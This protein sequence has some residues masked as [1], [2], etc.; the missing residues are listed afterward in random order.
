MVSAYVLVSAEPGKNR[1]VAS[2]LRSV[3][4]VKQVHVCWGQ[5]D[6]FVFL[7]VADQKTLSDTVL[8]KIQ[9]LRG[10][11]STDTHIVIAV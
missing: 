6:I 11:R 2:A 3:R 10:I 1:E 4:G 7:E 9:G 5:P 8:S